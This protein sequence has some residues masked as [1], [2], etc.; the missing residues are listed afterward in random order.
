MGPEVGV[1]EGLGKP[2]GSINPNLPIA[3]LRD[4]NPNLPV[5]VLRDRVWFQFENGLRSGVRVEGSGLRLGLGWGIGAQRR[6]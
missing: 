1:E 3:V 5:A 2:I 6:V 4:R